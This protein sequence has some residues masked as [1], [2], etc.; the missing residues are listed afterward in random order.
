[1]HHTELQEIITSLFTVFLQRR[2]VG[3]GVGVVG[4]QRQTLQSVSAAQVH[5]NSL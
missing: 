5:V 3:V 4:V 1:M 2:V